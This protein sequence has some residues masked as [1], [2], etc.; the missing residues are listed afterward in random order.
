M[1][2]YKNNKYHMC[3][4]KVKYIQHGEEITQYVMSEGN[5]WWVDFEEKW[6][7]TEIIEFIPVE[8]TEMQ[9]IRFEEINQLNI[10]EGFSTE[11]GDYVE[12]GIFPE[13][14]NHPL[15]SLRD[16]KKIEELENIIDILLGGDDNE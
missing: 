7:H 16:T 1:I 13:G 5:D 15:K 10:P 6:E 3:E 9:L 2:Y 11:L 8:P 4:H 12:S 14:I